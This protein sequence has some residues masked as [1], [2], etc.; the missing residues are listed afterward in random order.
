MLGITFNQII[1]QGLSQE[2]DIHAEILID[3]VLFQGLGTPELIGYQWIWQERRMSPWFGHTLERWRGI[4]IR[5]LWC[6]VY[7]HLDM[8]VGELRSFLWTLLINADLIFIKRIFAFFFLIQLEFEL[9]NPHSFHKIEW[10]IVM[11]LPIWLSWLSCFN[12]CQ[13]SLTFNTTGLSSIL[14]YYWWPFN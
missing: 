5:C 3:M 14:G 2:G 6:L 12:I 4:F 10:R 11:L 1:I 9:L 8:R 7:M 13:V